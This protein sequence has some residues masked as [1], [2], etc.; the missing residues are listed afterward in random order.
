MA[1]RISSLVIFILLTACAA[2]PPKPEAPPPAAQLPPPK[3]TLPAGIGAV[4]WSGQLKQVQPGQNLPEGIGFLV[5]QG[6]SGV[7]IPIDPANFKK[8]FVISD[9]KYTESN[10][11]S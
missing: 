6:F 11:L 5:K 1:F 2:T 10:F 7:K 3:Q 4:F 8:Y 9:F